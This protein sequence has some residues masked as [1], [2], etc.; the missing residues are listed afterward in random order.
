MG[1]AILIGSSFSSCNVLPYFPEGSVINSISLV[2]GWLSGM[3]CGL[4]IYSVYFSG[5]RSFGIEA[6]PTMEKIILDFRILQHV[7]E[8]KTRSELRTYFI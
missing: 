1:T 3:P 2:T 5:Q 4:N 8:F 6:S 7:L